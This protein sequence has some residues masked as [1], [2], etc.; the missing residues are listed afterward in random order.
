MSMKPSYFKIGSFVIAAG[1]LIL[2]AIVVFGSGLFAQEKTY[3]ETYFDDS[4]SGLSVGSP[5]E[6]RGVRI[7]QVEKI[8]FIRD[9]YKIS[10]QT[11][12]APKYEHYVMVLCSVLRENLPDISDEHRLARLEAMVS[13]GLRVRLSSNLLTG[14]AYLQADYLDPERF[15]VLEIGWKPRH[16]YVSSA[17]GELTTLKESVDKVLLRLQELDIDR[18]VATVERVLVSLEMAIADAK[19]GQISNDVRVLLADAS[20][21]VNDLETKKISLAAQQTLASADKAIADANVPVL[22]RDVQNL[23]AEVRQTNANLK[24]LLASPEPISGPSNLPETIAR[25]NRTLGRI[26]KLI[27][28]ERP[29]IEMILANFKEI[30]DNMKDLTESLKRHPSDLLFS[31]PP[32]Q[33]EALK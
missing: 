18:L 20:R 8:A 19:I 33:S 17:T 27:S 10:V 28:T 2:A 31:K 1:V 3:F 7:G 6:L 12:D 25:L 32:L 21:Q 26:D 13:R 9:E 16:L 15:K 29:Q 24:K 14:Q 22:S 30:S 5:V 4:V 11:S 23:I